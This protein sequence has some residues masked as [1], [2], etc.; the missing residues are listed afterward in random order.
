M[1]V[2][3]TRVAVGVRTLVAETRAACR[4]KAQRR[5]RDTILVDGSRPE[6][7]YHASIYRPQR[8]SE[9]S[10]KHALIQTEMHSEEDCLFKFNLTYTHPQ[11]K[12][13]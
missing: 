5:K 8:L 10:I 2:C 1:G 3:K 12:P 9:Y 11:A 7:I 6:F 4:D 13:F